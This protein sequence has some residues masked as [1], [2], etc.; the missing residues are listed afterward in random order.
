MSQISSNTIRTHTPSDRLLDRLHGK[1]SAPEFCLISIDDLLNNRATTSTEDLDSGRLNAWGNSFPAEELPAPGARIEI[2]GIPFA[3]ARSHAEGDNVRC[4][5]QVI[6]IPPGQ[7]D[8]IYL[9]AASERRSENTLWAHYADGTADPLR[10]GVSDFLDGTPAFGELPAF[11]TERMHY[12]HHVQ[13]GLPTTM[14]L[15]RVGM[16]RRGRATALRLPRCVALHVFALT[17][18]T[19]IDVRLADGAAR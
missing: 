2:A 17:L 3:W 9:L 5:G 14:W 12:P 11:S 19:G 6:E 1:A 15:S 13:Q 8:W 10:L 18:L 7:Y 4:E 16:P